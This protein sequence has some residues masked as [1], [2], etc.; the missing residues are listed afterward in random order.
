MIL[1]S[2]VHDPPKLMAMKYFMLKSN[3][4]YL[5]FIFTN[6]ILNTEFITFFYN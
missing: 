2:T 1:A 3:V 5:Q 4:V 6:Q